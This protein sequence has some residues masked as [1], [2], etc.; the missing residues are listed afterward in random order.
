MFFHRG[1]KDAKIDYCNTLL[2]ALREERERIT[3]ETN[4]HDLIE[5]AHQKAQ[6]QTPTRQSRLTLGGSYVG[7]S[8]MLALQR[9]LGVDSAWSREQGKSAFLF[10]KTSS[11][12][13]GLKTQGMTEANQKARDTIR[14]FYEDK[15]GVES[16]YD[17]VIQPAKKKP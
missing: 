2:T 15:A 3:P 14:Q 12:Y 5:K 16:E 6:D 9:Q 13:H 11:D 7:S 4:L 10:F 8:R 17:A 1:R